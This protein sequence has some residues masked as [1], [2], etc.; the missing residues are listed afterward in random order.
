MKRL[1]SLLHTFFNSL[2]VDWSRS[3]R[4]A[5]G[6]LGQWAL[7]LGNVLDGGMPAFIEEGQDGKEDPVVGFIECIK[8]MM[9]LWKDLVGLAFLLILQFCFEHPH[10]HFLI[11]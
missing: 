11:V 6:S 5:L 9:E 8:G 10:H 4:D 3:I 1:E 7:S 2:A